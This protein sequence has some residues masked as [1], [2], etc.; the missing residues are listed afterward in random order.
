KG[1]ANGHALYTE[2]LSQYGPAFFALLMVPFRLLRL[3]VT[4]DTARVLTALLGSVTAGLTAVATFRLTRSSAAAVISGACAVVVCLA[5]QEA[6]LHP[7][8]L[9][10]ICVVGIVVLAGGAPTSRVT[11]ALIGCLAAVAVLTKV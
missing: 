9:L 2:T 5:G 8:H 11:G 3:P 4:L 7:A 1:V 6:A 10:A